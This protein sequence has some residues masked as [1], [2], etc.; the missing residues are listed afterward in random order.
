[1]KGLYCRCQNFV[2]F[3]YILI[4][5]I[6]FG[7][8]NILV[9]RLLRVKCL[10]KFKKFHKQRK[11]HFIPGH[12]MVKIYIIIVFKLLQAVNVSNHSFAEVVVRLKCMLQFSK[13]IPQFVFAKLNTNFLP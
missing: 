11:L 2:E 9:Y 5:F 10:E 13:L 3:T 7:F 6:S 8:F 12:H 1:M 4:M